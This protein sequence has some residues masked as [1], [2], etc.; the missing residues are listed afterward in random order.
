MEELI[1]INCKK[2]DWGNIVKNFDSILGKKIGLNLDEMLRIEFENLKKI[3]FK[4]N[5]KLNGNNLIDGW[6]KIAQKKNY[7]LEPDKKYCNLWKG[8][9]DF[10][11][12]NINKFPKTKIDWVKK[13]KKYNLNYNNYK[14]NI[15]LY[16]DLPEYPE[17]IYQDFKNLKIELNCN[18]INKSITNMKKF[19]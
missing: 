2:L 16:N 6:K 11:Q 1:E 13:C 19:I 14:Q 12:I 17:E 15:I 9:Y 10:Y 5:E 4:L 3:A 18:K 8:W 7:C